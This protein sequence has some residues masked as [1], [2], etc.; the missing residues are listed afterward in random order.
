MSK[1][2]GAD[3]AKITNNSCAWTPGES[4]STM[5]RPRSVVRAI[6]TRA[7]ASPES[8][9]KQFC[10]NA[11]SGGVGSRLLNFSA[12][13]HEGCGSGGCCKKRCLDIIKKQSVYTF[14]CTEQPR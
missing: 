1:P 7:Y 3:N 8:K 5:G 11:L 10:I 9:A 14:K 12:A 6:Q 2:V 13:N 4:P